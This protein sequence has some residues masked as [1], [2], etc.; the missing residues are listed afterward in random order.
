MD[1]IEP[2]QQPGGFDLDVEQADGPA[3]P[4]CIVRCYGELDM[5]SAPRL[6]DTLRDIEGTDVLVDLCETTFIDSTGLS[7]LLNALRR[8]TRAGRRLAVACPPSI[9]RDTIRLT[10]LVETLRV[11]DDERGALALLAR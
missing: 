9:V 7:T 5:G 8:I 10:D 4:V 6:R 2:T 3:G 1:R 11:A